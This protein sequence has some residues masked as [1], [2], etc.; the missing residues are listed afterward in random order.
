MVI[1]SSKLFQNHNSISILGYT[2]SNQLK[3]EVQISANNHLRS[4]CHSHC[5]H[6]N[7][8]KFQITRKKN[9][10]RLYVDQIQMNTPS[11]RD[12]IIFLPHFTINNGIIQ[13]KFI[14]RRQSEFEISQINFERIRYY[15]IYLNNQ[16]NRKRLGKDRLINDTTR[17]PGL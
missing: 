4:A 6:K 1:N 15:R 2:N 10:I 17:P 13:F 9:K 7:V 5:V 16:F 14:C 11:K 3:P 12:P 8:L